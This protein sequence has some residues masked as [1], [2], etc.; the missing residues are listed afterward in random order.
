[1]LAAIKNLWLVRLIAVAWH[2]FNE[3]HSFALAGYLAYTGLLSFF[4]FMVFL[5]VSGSLIVGRDE[6]LLIVDQMFALT[7]QQVRTTLE[8]ILRSIIE[9]KHGLLA[10]ISAAVGLWAGSN[11]FEAARI[12]FNAAYD[13]KDK[14]NFLRRRLES[15]ALAAMAAVVFILLAFLIVLW[16]TI[17]RL[18]ELAGGSHWGTEIFSNLRYLVGLPMFFLLLVVLHTT[19]PKGKRR[20]YTLHLYTIH[21]EHWEV[22]VLPGVLA[23]TALWFLGATAFSL[24]LRFAPSF[25]GSYGAMAGVVIT[26]LFFY[27]SAVVIFFGAQINIA[28]AELR[29]GRQMDRGEITEDEPFLDPPSDEGEL[30]NMEGPNRPHKAV[31]KGLKSDPKAAHAPELRER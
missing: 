20:G 21:R 2:R 14:R 18:I 8:P 16:P 17:A 24:Y 10:M 6:S 4:P 30:G 7:P 1:M 26:L 5:I 3:D 31:L 29:R 25:A 27:M 22:S 23:T 11:A 15:L 19:L 12:G 28:R 13:V 9:S